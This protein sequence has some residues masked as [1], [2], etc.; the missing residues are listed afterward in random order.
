VR[1][2]TSGGSVDQRQPGAAVGPG[3]EPELA[4]RRLYVSVTMKFVVAQVGAAGW[5]G[6]S[7]WLSLPWVREL[8]AATSMVAALV[9]VSLVAYLPGWL[10]AFLAVSLLLDR[11]PP[12]RRSHPTVPV[13]V[14]V[15]ARNEATGSRRRSPTSPARTTRGGSRSWW[16]TTAPPMGPG[17]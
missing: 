6:V 13:T 1:R 3:T 9:V 5:L 10:V 8:A 11:Q 15:A 14:L 4:G 12:L 7:V 2:T 16:S 17:S